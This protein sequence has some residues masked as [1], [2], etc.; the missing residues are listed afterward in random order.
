MVWVCTLFD[1]PMQVVRFAKAQLSW[2][3]ESGDDGWVGVCDALK[4]SAQG[5]TWSELQSVMSEIL[6]DMLR[7]LL[8]EG[9]LKQTLTDLGW[10]PINPIPE[11][12]P[13][14][15]LRFDVPIVPNVAYA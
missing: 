13:S 14:D 6:D 1:R 12:M 15:G 2:R 9:T 4:L 10:V 7:G 8:Q 5:D 11:H 3:V